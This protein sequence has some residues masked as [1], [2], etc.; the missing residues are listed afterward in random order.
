MIDLNISRDIKDIRLFSRTVPAA[1]ILL[2]GLL[3]IFKLDFWPTVFILYA[4]AAVVFFWG[5]AS[6]ST[7]KPVYL[8]WSYFT[9]C[10]ALVLTSIV[11]GLVFYLGFTG[12]GLLMRLCGKDP[13]KK[14]LEPEAE[15][16]WILR[17]AVPFDPK[18]Y[19]K[20][21]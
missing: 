4:A 14:K 20:Q 21:F 18:T 7:L 2:G 15:S 17:P 6:P 10:V 9:R 11:L 5:M 8:G 19:E 12:V 16:Y 3:W 13:M 1:L